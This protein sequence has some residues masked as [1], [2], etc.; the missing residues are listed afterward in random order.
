MRLYAMQ[1]GCMSHVKGCA[2]W[3]AVF[4]P[5]IHV[6]TIQGELKVPVRL[7]EVGCRPEL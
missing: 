2:Y 4:E 6:G 7:S 1:P 5:Q 3:I